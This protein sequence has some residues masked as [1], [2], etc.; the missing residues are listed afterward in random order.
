MREVFVYLEGPSD[1]LSMKKLLNNVIQNAAHKGHRVEFLY[2]G[3]KETLLKKGLIKAI[4]ILRNKPNSCVFL[5]SD[6][7]PPNNPFPHRTF[8]E[9]KSGLEKK[10]VDKLDTKGCD[11]RMKERFYVHCFKYDLETLLLASEEQLLKRL[12]MKK[13]SRKWRIPVEEQNH[14]HPPKRVIEAL[15]SG[16]NKQ[17]KDTIDAPWIL[18]RSNY[19]DLTMRCPQNFKPFLDDLFNIIEQS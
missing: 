1:Q 19:A 3:G 8:E 7:Y 12:G 10:F 16:A 6:L 11:R 14:N 13:F 9:L 17:Y 2:L 4:N 15:F 5:V 18:E